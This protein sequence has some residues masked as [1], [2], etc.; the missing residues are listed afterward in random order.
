[1]VQRSHHGGTTAA[2]AILTSKEG[3]T[4]S[5]GGQRILQTKTKQPIVIVSKPSSTGHIE[6]ITTTSTTAAVA[7]SLQQPPTSSTNANVIVL[8]LGQEVSNATSTPAS[9][10]LANTMMASTP[11][12][13]VLSDILQMTGIMG[14]V[15]DETIQEQ[16]QQ[17]ETVHL[18]QPRLETKTLKKVPGDSSWVVLDSNGSSNNSKEESQGTLQEDNIDIFSQ[19]MASAEIDEFAANNIEITTE[20]EPEPNLIT[21]KPTNS[22]IIF[23]SP[24]DV[25]PQR[26]PPKLEDQMTLFSENNHGKSVVVEQ[27]GDEIISESEVLS[28]TECDFGT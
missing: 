24:H 20:K 1:M 15:E 21:P 12:N 3:I 17:H 13:N 4:A 23:A 14:S 6:Q 10:S 8:D 5:T 28:T 26:P 11:S 16:H 27:V 18:Q 7:S 25:M 19:A 9:S 2:K 22:S